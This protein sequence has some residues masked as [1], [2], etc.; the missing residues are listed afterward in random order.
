MTE[1]NTIDYLFAADCHGLYSVVEYSAESAFGI[2][3]ACMANPQ[4]F[5]VWG[6]IPLTKEVYQGLLDLI[7]TDDGKKEALNLIKKSKFHLPMTNSNRMKKYLSKIP[8]D[9]LDPLF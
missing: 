4:R 6:T 7:K 1:E 3:H 9:E 5:P 8:N 2:G